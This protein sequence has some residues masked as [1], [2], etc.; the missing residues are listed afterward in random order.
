MTPAP[1]GYQCPICTGRAKEGSFGAASYRTRSAVSKQAGKLPFFKLFGRTAATQMLIAA[2]VAI[3]IGMVATGHPTRADTLLRFGALPPVMPSSQWWRMFSAMFVHIGP[4]HLL[5][6]MYALTIFG[7]PIE[8]RY[9]KARFLALYFTA[10]FFGS[11]M[12]LALTQGG[13]RAG[14]S[15]AV[16]GILGAWI[17]YFLRLRHAPA[18][19][20][21]L[22][23]LFILVGINLFLGYSLGGIDNYAHLGGL[24]AGFVTGFALEQST[25]RPGAWK[26]AGAAGF[27]AVIV[28]GIVAATGSG[29]FV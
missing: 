5:F 27:A 9:G 16:F 11:A 17:A 7:P 15:G 10:G 29:R 2:N 8:N 26:L 25:T 23:S 6:N 1:V 4:L 12:S 20:A 19:R 18:A 13:I 28:A 21:Q 24:A 14:A 22:R 3:F